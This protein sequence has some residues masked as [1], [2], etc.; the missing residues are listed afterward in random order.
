MAKNF[1]LQDKQKS[2]IFVTKDK[3]QA[4]ILTISSIEYLQVL[5]RKAVWNFLLFLIVILKLF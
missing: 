1:N 5:T 3:R 2:C 4:I